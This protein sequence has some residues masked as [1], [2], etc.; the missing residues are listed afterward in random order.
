MYP[1]ALISPL[2]KKVKIPFSRDQ[3]MLLM[4]ALNELLLGFETFSAHIISGSIVPN[5]LYPI[6]F[7]PLSGLLLII[8]IFLQ[9]RFK[10]QALILASITLGL[11]LLVGLL[12]TWFHIQRAIL[13]FAPAG[14]RI[15]IPLIIWAPPVLAPLTFC[16]ISILGF[17]AIW[18][19]DPST[20]V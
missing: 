5:E 3:I 10:K 16:L 2:A 15:S 7:G 19:E 12:G 1:L 20:A 4:I 18:P 11:S 9:K 6:V 17:F 13:E 14:F 8:S